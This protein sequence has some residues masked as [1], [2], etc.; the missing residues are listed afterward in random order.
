MK[1]ATMSGSLWKK[2]HGIAAVM[3]LILQYCMTW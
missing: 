3:P 2:A 1:C